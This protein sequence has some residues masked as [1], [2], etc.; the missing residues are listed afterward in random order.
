MM[1]FEWDSKADIQFL[2]TASAS[3]VVSWLDKAYVLNNLDKQFVVRYK[4]LCRFI[5]IGQRYTLRFFRVDFESLV[6]F[7]SY[8]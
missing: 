7:M 4:N 5:E 2:T 3:V 1:F 8:S 6:G